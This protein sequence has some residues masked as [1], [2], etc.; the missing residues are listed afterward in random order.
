M[1]SVKKLIGKT[2][3]ISTEDGAKLNQEIRNELEKEQDKVVI[4]F[5]GIDLLISHFLNESIGKLYLDKNKWEML[6]E[7][8]SY[9]G[10]NKDDEILLKTKVI[11]T[12]KEKDKKEVLKI[13]N[14]ILRKR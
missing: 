10:M 5:E 11:P 3:C 6:D 9:V 13:Q 1:I 12:Y 7:Q 2:I 14:R 4:S 8:I